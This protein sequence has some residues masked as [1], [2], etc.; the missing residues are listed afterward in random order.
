MEVRQGVPALRQDDGVPFVRQRAFELVGV[1]EL[2]DIGAER[3]QGPDEPPRIE[4][5]NSTAWG[6]FSQTSYPGGSRKIR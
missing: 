2:P 4:R 6:L 1:G 5:Q 3:E